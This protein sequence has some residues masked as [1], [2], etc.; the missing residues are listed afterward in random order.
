MQRNGKKHKDEE[1]KYHQKLQGFDKALAE[2][3]GYLTEMA[4]NQEQLK[5]EM[6]IKEE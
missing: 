2:V 3:Q 6:K 1:M 4:K 5:E